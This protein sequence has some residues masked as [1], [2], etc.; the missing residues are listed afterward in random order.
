V[1]LVEHIPSAEQQGMSL[2]TMHWP[3]IGKPLLL[4]GLDFPHLLSFI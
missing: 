3:A 1:Q 4:I 2:S